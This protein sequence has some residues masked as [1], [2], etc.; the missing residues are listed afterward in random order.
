[1]YT[2]GGASY[3]IQVVNGLTGDFYIEDT[4]SADIYTPTMSGYKDISMD[5]L[6]NIY[7]S[8][9]AV[10]EVWKY[11]RN[12]IFVLSFGQDGG[13]GETLYRPRGIYAYQDIIYIADAGNNRIVRF[14]SSTAVQN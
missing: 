10:S 13:Q 1:M 3:S 9:T 4:D 11:N 12:G 14:Q 7:V 8:F 5:D 2:S 6:G